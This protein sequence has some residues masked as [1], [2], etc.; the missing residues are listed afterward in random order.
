MRL[1]SQLINDTS[2]VLQNL[3]KY[4]NGT[5]ILTFFVLSVVFPVF[6]FLDL[7]DSDSVILSFGSSL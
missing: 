5:T 1:I 2:R 7:N 4:Y 3:F 6:L